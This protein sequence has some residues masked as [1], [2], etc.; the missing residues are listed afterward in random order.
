MT[1]VRA[2]RRGIIGGAGAIA[3]S[4]DFNRANSTNLGETSVGDRAW[5]ELVGDWDIYNN[6]VRNLSGTN[7][8]AVVDAKAADVDIS[9][10]IASSGRDAIIFR[11]SDANNWWR[12]SRYGNSTSSQSCTDDPTYKTTC[13]DDGFCFYTS[14]GCSCPSCPG[15]SVVTGGCGSP[16]CFESGS[17]SA[18]GQ[19]CTT[20]YS[21]SYRVYLHKMVAGSLQQVN[22][23]TVSG[24]LANLRVNASGSA[25]TVYTTASTTQVVSDAFNVGAELHGVGRSTLGNYSGSAMDN[26]NLTP[27]T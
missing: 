25:I 4:D 24:G 5:Q 8:I 18:C 6:R 26:F 22:F 16:T 27:A 3:L 1:A 23:W 13:D 21:Y 10:D 15:T 7:P 20:N 14:A 19:A 2:R 17:S 12:F 9:L 11:A